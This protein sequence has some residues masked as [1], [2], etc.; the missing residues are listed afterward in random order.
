MYRMLGDV[1]DH[2]K[3][4]PPSGDKRRQRPPPNIPMG[5]GLKSTRR[6]QPFGKLFQASLVE[7]LSRSRLPLL[8]RWRRQSARLPPIRDPAM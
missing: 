3:K 5:E 1:S 8:R 4:I 2:L 6:R 7:S